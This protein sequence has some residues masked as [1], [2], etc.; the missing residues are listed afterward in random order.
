MQLFR[1][2]RTRIFLLIGLLVASPVVYWLASPLF[3]DVQ[4]NESP[5]PSEDLT[6]L[7]VGTFIDADSFHRTSGNATVIRT[8]NGSQI[9]RLSNFRTT[10]GPDLFVYFATDTTGKD[11]VNLGQLKGNI[12]D[13]NYDIPS[14]VDLSRY[15]YV[16]IW[17][18]AFAVLFG[19]AQLS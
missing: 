16:L 11:I 1:L 18:R 5:S 17:C 4:V 2:G 14:N 15:R 12:G 3:Y 19:S 9:L 6:N 7:A 10:N 13:Q 8:N